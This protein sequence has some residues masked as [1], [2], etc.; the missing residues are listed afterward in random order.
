[1]NA[2]ELQKRKGREEVLFDRKMEVLVRRHQL[3]EE[4]TSVEMSLYDQN[5]GETEDHGD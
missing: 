3:P 1:M 5:D 2:L 4:G